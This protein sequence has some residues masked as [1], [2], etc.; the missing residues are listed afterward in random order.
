MKYLLMIYAD[1]KGY[2]ALPPEEAKRGMEAY[3]A[4]TEALKKAG[5]HVG[6]ER[7]Q[8]VTTATT[9]RVVNCKTQVLNGPYTETKEQFG[10]YYMI[11]VPDLDAALAWAARCP[12]AHHGIV[13]VRPLWQMS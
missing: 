9:V 13:E 7:L 11:D 1:Q 3:V 8:P 4:Y 12:G 5:V 6:G 10:G 2:A